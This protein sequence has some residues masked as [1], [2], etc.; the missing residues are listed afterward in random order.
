MSEG[1]YVTFKMRQMAAPECA[2]MD[3][4]RKERKPLCERLSYLGATDS[5]EKMALKLR[6]ADIDSKVAILHDAAKA[7]MLG[8]VA[9]L[10]KQ[11]IGVLN[12]AH[13]AADVS[14]ASLA[15][16][17]ARH[18]EA[19]KAIVADQRLQ[20]EQRGNLRLVMGVAAEAL[21]EAIDVSTT[22]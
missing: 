18:H 15:A 10:V 20:N 12:A 7:K 3:T 14:I 8:H 13:G 22:E 16:E 17:N 5:D 21:N 9:T 6:I 1:R 2:Q 11:S 19:V 4:L